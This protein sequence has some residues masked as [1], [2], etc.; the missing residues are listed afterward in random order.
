MTAIT[1]KAVTSHALVATECGKAIGS[2]HKRPTGWIV[3]SR[4]GDVWPSVRRPGHLVNIKHV[5]RK[6]DA[7]ELLLALHTGERK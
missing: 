6:T 7:V 5:P 2:A 1:I 4:V 3:R